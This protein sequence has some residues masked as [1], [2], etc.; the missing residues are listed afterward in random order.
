MVVYQ[1]EGIWPRRC[2]QGGENVDPYSAIRMV[3]C[4]TFRT[5]TQPTLFSSYLIHLGT[6]SALVSHKYVSSTSICLNKSHTLT[7]ISNSEK[8]QNTMRGLIP[9]PILLRDFR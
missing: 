2:S 7:V 1:G 9:R 3:Q 5:W 6:S 8:F 4:L